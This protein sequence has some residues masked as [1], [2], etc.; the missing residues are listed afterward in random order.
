MD[1]DLIM[2]RKSRPGCDNMILEVCSDC[3]FRRM[4]LVVLDF[5]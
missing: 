3:I 5:K 4:M 1:F 2:V